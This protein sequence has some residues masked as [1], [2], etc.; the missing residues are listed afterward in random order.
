VNN[1]QIVKSV[2]S[3]QVI[4]WVLFIAVLLLVIGWS[5]FPVQ[6]SAQGVHLQDQKPEHIVAFDHSVHA[7]QAI[8]CRYCHGTIRAKTMQMPSVELCME[9]HRVTV[10][11]NPSVMHFTKLYKQTVQKN[12]NAGAFW[13]VLAKPSLLQFAHNTHQAL[14]SA[15]DCSHCHTLD[16]QKMQSKDCLDCH[17]HT[18]VQNMS[19]QDCSLCHQ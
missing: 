6:Y 9:C 12:E 7:L 2:F 17:L 4:F 16:K 11:D 13:Q 1:S 19:M 8:D 18:N 15:K 14:D 10:R 5:L 3:V